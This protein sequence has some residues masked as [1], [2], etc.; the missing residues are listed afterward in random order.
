VLLFA[1]RS[2][3]RDQEYFCEGLAEELINALAQVDGLR[4]VSRTASFQFRSSG[5]DVKEIGRK[6]SA[7]SLLEGSVQKLGDQLRV[8][9]QLIESNTGY[10]QWS[11]RFDGNIQDVFE[12]QDE[13]TAAVV[14]SLRGSMFTQR[15]KEALSRP[16]TEGAAYEFYLRGKQ[17]CP[18]GSESDLKRCAEMFEKAVALDPK[19]SPAYAG[20]AVAH[21]ML[22][23]WFGADQLHLSTAQRASQTALAL[24]PNLA[25]AHVARAITFHQMKLYA[26]AGEEFEHALRLVPSHW[27]ALHYYARSSFGSGQMEQAAALF[28]RAGDVRRE[29]YE[30][31]SLLSL[32]LRAL[33]RTNEAT[34]AAVEGIRRAERVLMLNPRDTRCLSITASVLVDAGEPE[35]ALEFAHR[36]LEY[37]PEGLSPLLNAACVHARLGKKEESL[38]LLQ[39]VFGR[40][41][42]HRSWIEH[43]PDYESLRDDPR[44]HVI[45]ANI[46]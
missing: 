38:A 44:F 35:R 6:L 13:I 21:A 1:D 36:A 3:A 19:Y 10:H 40:G 29:D 23:E 9:V 15:E 16:H 30:S 7:G 18:L 32:C 33:G 43:D 12:I 5:A 39:K 37:Q 14:S 20:L 28:R 22:Y 2:P 24:T 27:E 34:K 31:P 8:T 26:E 41:W 4:V 17:N 45:L 11:H 25:E 42:G 46:R